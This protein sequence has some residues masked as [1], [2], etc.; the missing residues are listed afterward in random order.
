M[1]CSRIFSGVLT[2]V[3]I[4]YTFDRGGVQFSVQTPL[5]AEPNAL[6]L[7]LAFRPFRFKVQHFPEPNARF[8]FSVQEKRPRT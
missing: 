4:F 1:H 2:V 8:R 7:N 3:G 6:N 5:N